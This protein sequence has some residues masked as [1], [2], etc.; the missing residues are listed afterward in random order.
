MNANWKIFLGGF[1]G[2]FK[3]AAAIVMAVVGVA[4][5]FVNGTLESPP[6]HGDKSANT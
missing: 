2:S 4:S 5:A 1:Y 3:L 6:H